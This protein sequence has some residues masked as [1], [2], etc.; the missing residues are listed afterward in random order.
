[1]NR[2]L[3]YLV[4]WFVWSCAPSNNRKEKS[5]KFYDINGLVDEQIHWLSS[6][7]PSVS[8]TAT[9]NGKKEQ[10]RI[11]PMDSVGWAKELTIFKSAD[12]NRSIL[13]D[14]YSIAESIDSNATRVVYQSKYPAST[15][16]EELVIELD[17]NR[18]PVRI[19]ARLDNSNELFNSAK[20]IELNFRDVEGRRLISSYHTEGW[21]K[22]ISKDTASYV[23]RS[24]ITY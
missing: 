24:E 22:M 15:E 18:K 3:I 4:L 20:I 2:W 1:M 16:V 9:I 7:S 23:V 5:A 19:H 13:S 10:R 11:R 8:K 14:S 21:Q 17:K 12:I 6:I